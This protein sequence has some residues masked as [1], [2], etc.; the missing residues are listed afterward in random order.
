MSDRQNKTIVLSGI[1]ATGKLHLGNYLGAIKNFLALQENPDN[2]CYFFIADYH[3]LT[4]STD[5]DALRENIIQVAIDYLAAG[6]DPEKSKLYVQS[7]IPEIAELSLLLAMIEPMSELMRCT[8]FKEK[9]KKQPENV[10]L[11]LLS[12]PVLM[13]ADI[14]GPKSHLV[15]VGEDQLQHVEMAR[16]IARR[17][18]NQYGVIFPLPEALIEK[19][20]RVPGLDGTGKMGKSEGNTIDLV[21]S[22]EAIGSKIKVAVTDPNRKTRSDP[23]DPYKCNIHM[24]HDFTNTDARWKEIATACKTAAV[25]CVDCKQELARNVNTIISPIRE[26]RRELENRRD[27][28]ID[29]LRTCGA[30]VRAIVK[31]SV[32]EAREKMG[33]PTL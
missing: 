6:I 16:D 1:R 25:G 14:L 22:E 7:S 29:V 31:E 20:I 27:Y 13:A 21:D 19:A 8:T 15:P 26:R 12:Y 24:L 18:N 11:G 5:P 17:F 33:L 10:N 32:R 30:H 4:T 28:V 3:T 2:T 23:G 9:A